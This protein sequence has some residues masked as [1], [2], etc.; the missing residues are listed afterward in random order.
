MPCGLGH[1]QRGVREGPPMASCQDPKDRHSV[2]GRAGQA[3]AGL[4]LLSRMAA[5]PFWGLVL[6]LGGAAL[7]LQGLVGVGGEVLMTFQLCTATIY[8][9]NL[10]DQAPSLLWFPIDS[11]KD[12]SGGLKDP[13]DLQP[14]GVCLPRWGE[15]APEH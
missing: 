4:R 6:W 10:F 12:R 9:L 15:D 3:E 1:I 11:E 8:L 13:S 2:P 7:R 5:L 14:S